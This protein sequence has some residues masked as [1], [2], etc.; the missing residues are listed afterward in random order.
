MLYQV[1]NMTK[2][3][4][5]A[6]SV[7][8]ANTF[9]RRAVGLLGRSSLSDGEGILITPCNCVHTWFMRFV[10]DVVFLARDLT[11]LRTIENLRPWRVS[12]LIPGARHVLELPAGKI[13]ASRTEVGDRLKIE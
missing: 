11:V 13:A 10:I 7:V 9:W 6:T 8:K 5:L 12:P 1:V 3:L 4:V 2:G